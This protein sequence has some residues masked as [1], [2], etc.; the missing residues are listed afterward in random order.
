[1]VSSRILAHVDEIAEILAVLGNGKRI[2]IIYHLIHEELP[3]NVLARK[4]G[5]SQSALSQHL[6]KLRERRIVQTR[7]DRQMIYYSCASRTIR[8]ILREVDEIVS[9]EPAQ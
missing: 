6:A 4:V 3:V 9:R 5:L 8:D 7:R 1:M 2:A